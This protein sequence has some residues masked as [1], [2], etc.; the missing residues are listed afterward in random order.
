MRLNA[1]YWLDTWGNVGRDI[2][3]YCIDTT[4]WQMGPSWRWSRE[5]RNPCPYCNRRAG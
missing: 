5:Q 3:E 2:L 4:S 1:D